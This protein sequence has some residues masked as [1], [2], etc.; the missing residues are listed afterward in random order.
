[1][2]VLLKLGFES[3]AFPH[4]DV[5]MRAKF[6]G[7]S[8]RVFAVDDFV[9]LHWVDSEYFRSRF[10]ASSF[11]LFHRPE[12]VRRGQSNVVVAFAPVGEML[13]ARIRLGL[14]EM[15][16]FET[17]VVARCQVGEVKGSETLAIDLRSCWAERLVVFLNGQRPREKPKVQ[18]FD[19]PGNRCDQVRYGQSEMGGGERSC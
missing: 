12:D 1:M 10:S 2:S 6:D 17:H 13:A 8:P 16:K 15:E 11:K 4:L 7:I 14:F 18:G 3:G 5:W 9:V 19:V